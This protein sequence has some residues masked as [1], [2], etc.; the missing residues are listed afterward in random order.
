[1]QHSTSTFPNPVKATPPALRKAYVP[2]DPATR[3]LKNQTGECALELTIDENGKA[4]GTQR[5]QQTHESMCNHAV[6]ALKLWE[7]APASRDGSDLP[8]TVTTPFGCTLD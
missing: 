6:N 2:L 3:I 1:M 5:A 8:I 7:D 4:T